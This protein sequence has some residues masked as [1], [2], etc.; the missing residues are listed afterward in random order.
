VGSTDLHRICSEVVNDFREA[1]GGRSLTFEV[2]GESGAGTWDENRSEQALP[3]LVSNAI[4]HSQ[5]GSPVAVRVLITGNPVEVEVHNEGHIAD[6]IRPLL[7]NPFTAGGKSRGRSGGPGLGLFVAK[8]ITEAHGGEV[9][10]HSK[11][12][13]GTT[14]RIV[15]PREPLASRSV[16]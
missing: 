3:N 6:D 9:Q 15:L 12:E 7:F 16:A 5:S 1:A 13:N 14:F 2:T 8:A 10:V 4:Q 11:P